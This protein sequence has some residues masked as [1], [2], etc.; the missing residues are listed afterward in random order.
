MDTEWRR[1]FKQ[2]FI[3]TSVG[4][5]IAAWQTVRFTGSPKRAGRR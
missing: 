2:F 1:W 5:P 3:G 4:S